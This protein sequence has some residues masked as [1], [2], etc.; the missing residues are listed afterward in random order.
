MPEIWGYTRVSTD[1]QQ[2]ALQEDALKKAGCI[3]VFPDKVSSRKAERP[4]FEELKKVLSPGD[5]VIVYRLDRLGRDR[6][7]LEEK[8]NYFRT[9]GVKFVSLAEQID[10]STANGKFI[11]DMMVSLAEF[12]RELLRE[13]TIA[14]IAAAR[15][16]GKVGGREPALKADE[17]RQLKVLYD[18]RNISIKRL[19]D[20]FKISRA[21]LYKYVK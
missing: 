13:R 20:M 17:I 5:T 9:H 7:D 12:E 1:K 6:K 4:G 3:K 19:C 21:T 2:A 15:A 11:Y 18:D 10:T 16:R 14:G 8:I